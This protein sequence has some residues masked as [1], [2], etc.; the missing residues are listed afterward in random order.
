MTLS[1]KVIFLDL[2]MWMNIDSQKIEC[3]PHAKEENLFLHMLLN[4][5]HSPNALKGM[6]S[7]T[8]ERI[9]NNCSNKEHCVQETKQLHQH[10]ASTC[11]NPN[12]L[13]TLFKETAKKT[14]QK[15]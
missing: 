5:A 4:L 1:E 14:Q 13:S 15:H 2:I 11:Y 9:W 12:Y 7:I 6:T 3:K 8:M 10:L